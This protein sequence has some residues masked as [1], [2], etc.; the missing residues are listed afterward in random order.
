MLGY[1][2]A[3]SVVSNGGFGQGT[4][5]I[6][7]DNVQCSGNETRIDLCSFPGWGIHDCSHYE[8]AGVVCNSKYAKLKVLCNVVTTLRGKQTEASTSAALYKLVST[9]LPSSV[10]VNSYYIAIVIYS[11]SSSPVL[12]NSLVLTLS[13]DCLCHS[14]TM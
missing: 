4:G 6:W 9:P 2:R 12:L 10:T 11:F 5:P 14:A 7:M 8:D 13:S 3:I 1:D